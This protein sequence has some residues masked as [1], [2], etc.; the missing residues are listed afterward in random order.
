MDDANNNDATVDWTD[1]VA[2]FPTRTAKTEKV[3]DW[4]YD[5]LE[6]RTFNDQE[7]E[8]FVS[9]VWLDGEDIHTLS[10]DELDESFP[11]SLGDYGLEARPYRFEQMRRY[12]LTDVIRARKQAC[13]HHFYSE[14]GLLPTLLSG[15]LFKIENADTRSWHRE[16]S[17]SSRAPLAAEIWICRSWHGAAADSM[18]L[19]LASV[20]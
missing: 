5:F 18:S 12:L 15:L 9:R 20:A 1:Q 11:R 17:H 8:A 16:D 4:L 14:G 10:K 19:L 3:Q 13:R 2:R 7:I 6:R